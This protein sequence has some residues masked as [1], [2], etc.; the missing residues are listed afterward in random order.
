MPLVRLRAVSTSTYIA[1]ASARRGP[2]CS[3]RLETAL[4]PVEALDRQDR[5]GGHRRRTVTLR[6]DRPIRGVGPLSARATPRTPASRVRGAARE[7]PSDISRSAVPTAIARVEGSAAAARR[8]GSRRAGRRRSRRRRR[9]RRLPGPLHERRRRALHDLSADDRA[10]RDDGARRRRAARHASRAARGSGRS[11]AAGSTGRSR[12][13]GR[14][15]IASST[16]G[17]TRACSAPRNSSPSIG[18]AALPTI[19][20]SWNGHSRPCART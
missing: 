16:S 1:S 7:A 9:P 10:D 20:N 3:A 6:D 18:P 5:K 19:M 11:T 4:G 14:E 2:A 8:R 17:V 13:R 15:A 12:S